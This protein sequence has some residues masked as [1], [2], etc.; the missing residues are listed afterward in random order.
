MPSFVA[1]REDPKWAEVSPEMM[2][3]SMQGSG[4]SRSEGKSLSRVQGA[5]SNS[6]GPGW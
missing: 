1:L 2:K 5:A 6:L 3:P 4:E